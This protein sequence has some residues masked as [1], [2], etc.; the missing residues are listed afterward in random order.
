MNIVHYLPTIRLAEG[1]VVRAVLDVCTLMA[2]RGHRVTLACWDP[3]DV[4]AAWAAEPGRSPGV[5]R[6]DRPGRGGLL[7]STALACSDER[8]ADAD[9]LHLHTPWDLA[10]LQLARQARRR[11]KPYVISVHGMLDVWSM[12]QKALKK[13]LFLALFARRLLNGAAAVHCTAEAERTQASRWFDGVRAVVVPLVFDLSDFRILPGPYAARAAFPVAASADCKLLFLSRLHPKKGA[14]VFLRAG[15][16][17]QSRGQHVQL[18]LAGT[19][20]AAY[21]AGLKRLAQE[22][23]IGERTHFLGL[24]VG[25]NKLS[26]FQ[27]ADLF[28]LPTSQENFGFVFP[29]ALACRTPV[30]TTKGVDIWPE[31]EASGGAVIAER[32]AEAIAD[33]AAP[34]LKNSPLR[35]QMGEKGRE[36]VLSA[37][38]ND[39][40]SERFEAMYAG[41]RG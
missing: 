4:P 23:G 8:L 41:S 11:G 1:G 7:S 14:E 25:Q 30:V 21:T 16:L 15:A 33:A 26:L 22:L 18:L 39:R 13:K 19:G 28:I 24:V 6:L 20:E 29:E 32:T 35:Q 37:L 31:L 34:I 27:A 3:A 40:V 10:N 2:R 9:V 38:D 17:L 5:L 12:A 36:W